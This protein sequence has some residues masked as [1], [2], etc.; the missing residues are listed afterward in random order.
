MLK[1]TKHNSSYVAE[2]L[3]IFGAKMAGYGLCSYF[4]RGLNTN[5]TEAA[6]G[7]DK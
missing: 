6:L 4:A 7:T 5:L 1:P 2:V 3:V